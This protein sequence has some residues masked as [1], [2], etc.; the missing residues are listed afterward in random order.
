[1]HTTFGVYRQLLDSVSSSFDGPAALAPQKWHLPDYAV[2][3]VH[4]WRLPPVG[5]FDFFPGTSGDDNLTGTTGDDF[6]DL[7]TGGKDTA[8]G[9]AGNDGFTFGATFAKT[10]SVDGGDDFDFVQ[11]EG[12]YSTQ[13]K[14]AATTM[15]GVEE[16]DMVGNHNYSIKFDDANVVPIGA[17]DGNFDPSFIVFAEE[18]AG[19]SVSID[20]S[21]EVDAAFQIFT[22]AGDDTI[23][24]GGGI[25]FIRPGTGTNVIDGGGGEDRVSH[26]SLGSA[27]TI[28]LS[29]TGPQTIAPGTTNTYNHIED[30]SGTP[31]ADSLTGNNGANWLR[32]AEGADIL[33][34]NKGNDRMEG[35]LDADTI[36][37]GQGDDHYLYGIFG[38]YEAADEST[39]STFDTIIGFDFSQ[40][41]FV[42]P[43][44][45]AAID[46]KVKNGTL[47]DATFD[48]DLAAKVN[49]A[50]LGVSDAVLFTP[51]AGDHAGETFLIVDCNGLAGYQAGA[52][53]VVRLQ[54][55]V[56]ASS[57][58]TTDFIWQ[59]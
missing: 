43:F 21:A 6:F 29:I 41:H 36:D 45:V 4:V 22:G 57:I 5:T 47:S 40:D 16:L 17:N 46:T 14:L 13:I 19:F 8:S 33:T 50:K 20:A 59:P 24:T 35:S 2:N 44:A 3:M 39:G 48:A 56:H 9:L 31:F 58:D 28:D 49:A 27:V 32:G 18:S 23:K 15:T 55:A 52:D 26:Y 37:G 38:D 7:S 53:M 12:D 10:D 54:T 1:M 30:V 42:L 51:N 25:D 11:I 34:G